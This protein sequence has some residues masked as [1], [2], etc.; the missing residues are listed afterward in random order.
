M[1]ENPDE[2][3]V[4]RRAELL[5]E[6]R[7]AG[8]DEPDQ[9]ARAILDESDDRTDHPERTRQESTQTPDPEA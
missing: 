4:D 2:A 6:E 7:A 8:S 9:Q 5:P 3:R 1:T